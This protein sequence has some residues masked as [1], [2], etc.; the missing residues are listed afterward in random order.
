MLA[1]EAGC[2]V[3]ERGVFAVDRGIWEHPSFANEPLTEREAWT[4]LIGEASFKARTKRIGSV[5][6]ELK[7]G[8]VAASLRFMAD[9]WQWSEPRVR[10][11]L[12][13]LKTDAMIDASTDAGITVITI[14]NYDKYQKVSLP[15]D[16]GNDAQTDAAATQQRRKVESTEST[17]GSS[18]LRSAP[19]RASAPIYTDSRHE[20]WGEGVP[21]LISMGIVESSARSNIGRW[22]KT[23]RDDA[24]A[25]LGAIQRA[26]DNRVHN[27]IPWIT[28]ALARPTNGTAPHDFRTNFRSQQ[29]GSAPVL[30]G[31]AAATER[32][33]RE[34]SAAGQQRQ[35]PVDA[36]PA[37]RDDPELFGA[38]AGAA[39]YR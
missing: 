20:L 38:G 9:K 39:T 21:I 37:E 31:V 23:M 1:R 3:S 4:W 15:R 19:P 28:H 35:V 10:R 29:S 27:P 18:E 2:T 6:I 26:R 36:D 24:Q 25:V 12:K 22:L 11:F 14:C 30:A 8:Q 32:R 16:A 34:R 33:A 13:R 17:E 5:L 7:R